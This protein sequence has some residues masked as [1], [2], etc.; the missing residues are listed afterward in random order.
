MERQRRIYSLEFKL[1][2]VELSNERGSSTIVAR[3]LNISSDNIKRWKKEYNQGKLTGKIVSVKSKEEQ[4]L[5]LLRKELADVKM[6]RDIFKKGGQHLFQERQVKFEFI[7]Q[8][9]YLFTVEKMCQVF[10]INKSSYYKWLIRVPSKRALYNQI[11]LEEIKRIYYYNRK[12]YGSPRITKE[13]KM[14]GFI[15]S[16]ELVRKLMKKEFLQSIVKRKFKVTTDS[17]HKYPVVE[18]NLNREFTVSRENQTWVSDITYVRTGQGW[19]YLTSVIDLFDRKVIGWALSA[20]MSAKD[21]NIKAF[22]MALINR[23]I[24]NNQSLIFHSDRGIQYACEE[25]VCELNKQKSIIRSMSRKGNCWDNAVAESFF[26]TLK[27][28]LI[29]QNRYL[30]RQEAELSIFEYIETFYNT[31]RRH[32]QLNNLTILEYQKL[33]N[34]NLKMAA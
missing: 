34:N 18:N 29:Y 11:L 27:V 17:S 5:I 1:K 7:K 8:N 30:T 16:K 26:K 13:L 3:E 22:K 14:L 20:T 31:N 6:E 24:K 25:F 9:K 28:E 32:K 19:L 12:R 15:A 10:K 21:T 2:A 33:I 4:E 23:P